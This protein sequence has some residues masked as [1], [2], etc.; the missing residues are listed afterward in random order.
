MKP[1]LCVVLVCCVFLVVAPAQTEKR[2]VD[3]TAN[4][5]SLLRERRDTFR[6]ILDIVKAQHEE[7]GAQLDAVLQASNQLL[8]AELQLA[9]SRDERIRLHEK[10]VKNFKELDDVARRGHD[11]GTVSAKKMLL[12]KAARLQAEVDHLRAEAKS[13]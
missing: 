5:D 8:D 1:M 4:I 3:T 7:R 2:D 13:D 12:V 9:E 10:R 11:A 6:Q